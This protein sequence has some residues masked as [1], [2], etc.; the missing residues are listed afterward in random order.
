MWA[1]Q[2]M[3]LDQQAS[4][5]IAESSDTILQLAHEVVKRNHLEQRY[6]VF[7]VFM[8]GF[9]ATSAS[10]KTLAV[11]ILKYFERETIGRN[12]EVSRKLLEAVYQK[13]DERLMQNEICMDVDWIEIMRQKGTE[14]VHFGI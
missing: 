5:D 6:M 7:P 4:K 14:V 8:A 11:D 3:T 1:T 2:Q 13:Q 9:A 10:E 12:T